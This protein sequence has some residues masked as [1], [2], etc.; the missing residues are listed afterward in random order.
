MDGSPSTM[1][2]AAAATGNREKEGSV[3]SGSTTFSGGGGRGSSGGRLLSLSSTAGKGGWGPG[4]GIPGGDGPLSPGAASTREDGEG[5]GRSGISAA[6]LMTCL[7]LAG[8]EWGPRAL[9]DV[10][11]VG[12][13]KA[14]RMQRARTPGAGGAR[15]PLSPAWC[16]YR[17][18]EEGSRAI[19]REEG[20]IDVI[21]VT[22]QTTN[23]VTALLCSERT[24]IFIFFITQASCFF[25]FAYTL[26]PGQAATVST[27]R[28]Y[29]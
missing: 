15:G 23:V 12:A 13:L 11:W 20:V 25:C 14:V 9:F 3:V 27:V 4:V 29:Q 10:F 26:E 5:E 16:V 21:D 19:Q 17:S 22:V 7:G 6:S 28:C 18:L 1:L 2:A 24:Y 8:A